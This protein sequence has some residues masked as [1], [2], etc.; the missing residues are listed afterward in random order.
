MPIIANTNLDIYP[1]ALGGNTFGWTSDEATSHAVLDAFVEQGGNF[2]DTADGYSA[3]V[4]GN[5][6]GES[7]TIIGSW[8]AKNPTSELIVATK[9]STHPDYKGLA[10]ANIAEAADASLARLGVDALDLYYAHFDDPEQDIEDIAAAFD[11]LVSAGKA[12]YVGISNFS[13][14]RAQAW[15]D[16]SKA[17]GLAVPVALQVQYNL[18]TR[19]K[20][21]DLYAPLAAANDLSVL[22]YY[23]L[24]SGFLSGKYRSEDDLGASPRGGGAQQYLTPDGFDVL[25]ALDEIAASHETSVATVALAWLLTRPNVIAPLASARTVEQ[26]PDLMAAGS[27][28]LTDREVAL[29]D[30]AS[31]S[32]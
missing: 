13:P 14:E 31:S 32:F 10:P 8:K 3:W 29:L 19:A 2:V 7:E 25:G 22:P 28:V 24:A 5:S 15:I 30:A 1:L 20:F 12:R 11:Q 26:L 21:E 16:H 18:V 23:S 17:A 6:G 27:L 9:V 4:P